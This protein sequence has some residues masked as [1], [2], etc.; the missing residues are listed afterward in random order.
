MLV[1]N[2]SSFCCI[3]FLFITIAMCWLLSCLFLFFYHFFLVVVQV[4]FIIDT[5]A[6]FSFVYTLE[7]H[8]DQ[9]YSCSLI[10]VF[11]QLFFVLYFVD[12]CISCNTFY[13]YCILFKCTYCVS[14]PLKEAFEW[15]KISF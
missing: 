11:S 13:L 1:Q 3:V 9:S 6:F 14:L 5:C 7:D 4:S 2:V 10:L 12:A 15:K 8:D